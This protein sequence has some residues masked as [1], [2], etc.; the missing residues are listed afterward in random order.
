M[1]EFLIIAVA[2]FLQTSGIVTG[3]CDWRYLKHYDQKHCDLIKD[4]NG[5]P[6]RY[7]CQSVPE[8]MLL[9][10]LHEGKL[11]SIGEKIDEKCESCTCQGNSI[12]GASIDCAAV[13][14]PDW[15]AKDKDCY[16]GYEAGAC[17]PTEMCPS[18]KNA[19]KR[20]ADM[21]KK[22]TTSAGMYHPMT[23]ASRAFAQKIHLD[24]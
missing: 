17:C 15:E 3:D 6:E 20:F 2:V 12:E 1:K 11:Y 18:E 8:N 23:R 24:K 4:E 19:R 22:I 13:D 16:M 10:C 7:Q 14:C 9:K 21:E 5:C